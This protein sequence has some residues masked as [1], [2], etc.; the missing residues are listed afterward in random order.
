MAEDFRFIYRR[1][2]GR[3]Y[4]QI[5]VPTALRERMGRKLIQWSL[6]TSEKTLAQDRRWAYVNGWGRA[7][8]KALADET[9]TRE[10]IEE[11]AA[12]EVERQKTLERGL[13]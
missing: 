6:D 1:R 10:Q 3:F 4:V 8:D 11:L 9:M 7:F 13:D 12:H 5:T 2:G